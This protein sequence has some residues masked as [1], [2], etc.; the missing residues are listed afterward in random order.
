MGK[1]RFH[2]K[3]RRFMPQKFAESLLRAVP[4]WVQSFQ[5]SRK[6]VTFMV[7]PQHILPF[8]AFLRDYSNTQCKQLMDITTIDNPSRPARFQI[9]YHLLSVQYN[10]RVR[11]K[12]CV[13]EATL[14]L[15]RL[16]GT[17]SLGYVWC[18][19][20]GASRSAAHSH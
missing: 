9:V 11:V 18:V 2:N 13:D 15:C 10:A 12:S 7:Y 14:L 1:T 6:E 19:L 8:L 5:F 16:V 3:D 20:F 4:K 17:G